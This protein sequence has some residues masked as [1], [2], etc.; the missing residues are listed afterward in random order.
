MKELLELKQLINNATTNDK[1]TLNALNEKQYPHLHSFFC[2][3]IEAYDTITDL[4]ESFL[5]EKNINKGD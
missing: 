2:G 5:K 3:R 1:S 4:I